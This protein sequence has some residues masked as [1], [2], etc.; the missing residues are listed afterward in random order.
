M[1][2]LYQAQ[3]AVTQRLDRVLGEGHGLSFADLMILLQLDRAGGHRRRLD[4]ARDLHVSTLV[5]TRAL[6]PLER[7]GLLDHEPNP[8]DPRAADV[9]LTDTGRS[10]L[11]DARA[12]AEG[13][14]RRLF[15]E[16]GRTAGWDQGDLRQFAQF[17]TRIG[18]EA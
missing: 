14:S 9:L 7:I 17:L 15:S 4:L 6:G 13:A 2:R 5:L 16:Y 11:S 3:G 8:G 10:L 12:T 18:G 1:V